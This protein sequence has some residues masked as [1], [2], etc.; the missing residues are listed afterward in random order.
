MAD[1]P[2]GLDFISALGMPPVDYIRMAAKL[3][4]AEV[5]LGPRPITTNP[6]GYPAWSLTDDAGL[7]REVKAALADTD[8]GVSSGEGCFL[9]EHLPADAHAA[10]LDIFADLG[11][12]TISVVV[13]DPDAARGAEQAARLVEL[14]SVRGMKGAVEFIP[15]TAVGDLP[16]AVALVDTVGS[17]RLGVVIDTMHLFRSG[18]GVANFAALDPALVAQVQ[19]CDVPLINDA[20]DYGQEAGHERLSPGEGELPLA[21]FVAAIPAG[22][23][24]SLE[25]PMLSKATAGIG[26][27]ERLAPA[28]AATRALFS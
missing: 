1:T 10:T 21:D 23:P 20:M 24:V 4:F 14:A 11:T 13:L 28:L 6:H 17:D 16:A 7:R 22:V 2:I 8:L 12:R 27:E 15:G 26:P 25:V 18:A 5:S 9:M 19:L 3:G